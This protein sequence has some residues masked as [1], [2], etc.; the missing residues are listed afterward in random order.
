[1]LPGQKSAEKAGLRAIAGTGFLL[2]R[3]NLSEPIPY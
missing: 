3:T 2:F 1:L